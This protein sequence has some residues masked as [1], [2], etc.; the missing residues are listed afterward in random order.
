MYSK[1]Q[2]CHT[3]KVSVKHSE[4]H[5]LRG[6]LNLEGGGGGGGG[7]GDGDGMRL[8]AY[9]TLRGTRWALITFNL[10]KLLPVK[11]TSVCFVFQAPKQ[12]LCL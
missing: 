8:V 12:W 5:C 10:M 11:F 9:L 6:S 4:K 3:V 2:R 1:T 7:E